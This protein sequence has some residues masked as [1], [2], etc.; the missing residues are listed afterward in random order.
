MKTYTE[1]KA[2][3]RKI[4]CKGIQKHRLFLASVEASI[5]KKQILDSENM[6]AKNFEKS[7]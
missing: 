3:T 1:I 5:A 2:Y 7:T 4:G 6:I